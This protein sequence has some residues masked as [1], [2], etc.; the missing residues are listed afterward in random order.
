[1]TNLWPDSPR[2]EREDPNKI[3]NEKGEISTDNAKIQKTIREYSEQ[4]YANKFDKMEEMDNFLE[5]YSP[6]QMNQ[7]EII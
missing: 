2:R 6:I 4:L 7:E 3:R 5:T 1:M